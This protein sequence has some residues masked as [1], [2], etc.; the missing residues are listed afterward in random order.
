MSGRGRNGPGRSSNNYR[1]RRGGFQCGRSSNSSGRGNNNAGVQRVYKFFPHSGNKQQSATYELVKDHILSKIQREYKNSK[2][3][4]LSLRN[5]Q[6]E[7]METHK[8]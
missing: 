2:D 1:G 8:P 6:L 7:D 4:I 3:V 5:L